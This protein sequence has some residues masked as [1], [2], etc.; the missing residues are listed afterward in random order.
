MHWS[1]GA[2]SLETVE[3]CQLLPGFR[4]QRLVAT[5]VVV[6]VGS[7]LIVGVTINCTNVTWSEQQDA[8]SI[9]PCWTDREG[10]T[11]IL[12]RQGCVASLAICRRLNSKLTYL[13]RPDFVADSEYLESSICCARNL[14]RGLKKLLGISKQRRN[15]TAYCHVARNHIETR[16]RRRAAQQQREE[17]ISLSRGAWIRL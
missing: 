2:A 7:L 6:I 14:L 9:S 11:D 3:Q 12:E 8:E 10:A 17:A 5:S 4:S 1:E 15:S 16:A 13:S